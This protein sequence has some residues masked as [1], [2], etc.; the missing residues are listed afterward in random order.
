MGAR[1]DAANHL[2]LL[3]EK[4]VQVAPPGEAAL[5]GLTAEL[6]RWRAESLQEELHVQ[7]DAVPPDPQALTDF[8][9]DYVAAREAVLD[10]MT[11]SERAKAAK[12]LGM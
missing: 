2:G 3:L 1:V 9:E 6:R 10:S 5:E 7:A 8:Q 4:D 12:A 11:P